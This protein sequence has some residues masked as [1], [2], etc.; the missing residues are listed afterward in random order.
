[1]QWKP[2]TDQESLTCYPSIH[3]ADT[4][5]QHTLQ[6]L[7]CIKEAAKAQNSR[8]ADTVKIV[9]QL[10]EPKQ[11]VQQSK[12]LQHLRRLGKRHEA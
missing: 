6:N 4:L 3:S 7:T 11:E 5:S 12:Q 9:V 10:E 1:M 8:Q 2:I